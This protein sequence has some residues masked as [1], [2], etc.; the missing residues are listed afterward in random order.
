MSRLGEPTYVAWP[1]HQF[2][3]PFCPDRVGSEDRKGHLYVNEEKGYF[4]HRCEARGRIPWLLRIIGITEEEMQGPAPSETDLLRPLKFVAAPTQVVAQAV[5]TVELPEN[6]YKV[7]DVPEVHFYA[8]RRGIT[9]FDCDHYGL[10]A[11]YDNRGAARLLFPDYQGDSLVYW[12]ARA[13]DPKVQP[14]YLC[15]EDSEKSLCAWNINRL[16]PDRPIYVAEGIMSARACG[17]NSTAVYGKYLSK[18]QM[19]MIARRSG[20]SGVRIVFDSGAKQNALKAAEMFLRHATP[21]GVVL[22]PGDDTDPDEML[23]RDLAGLHLLLLNSAPLNEDGLDR[24]RMEV[25]DHESRE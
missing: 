21:C 7:W 24:L 9:N 22:L 10:L 11:W 15:A 14:K 13:V 18:P 5:E 6:V 4:C 1:E 20:E 23:Q 19:L 3:C 25:A 8:N 16:Q 2:R 12:T 17:S